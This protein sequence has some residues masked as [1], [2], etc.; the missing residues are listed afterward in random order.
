MPYRSLPYHEYFINT[1]EDFN[2]TG[3]L[4]YRVDYSACGY[5]SGW[6]SNLFGISHEVNYE[7]H[8]DGEREAI[9][10]NFQRTVGFS[11][12]FANIFEFAAKYY[13]AIDFEG[14][15]LQLRVH[16]GWANMYRAIKHEIRNGWKELHEL[17][18]E[19]E[20]EVVGWSLGSGIASLCA[21][22]LN[23]NFGL[24]PILYTFGSVR[25]FKG[26]R[27][28]GKRLR[29]Y[30]DGVCTRAYN[31]ADVNDLITYMPPF[32]G[33]MMIDRV[34]LGTDKRRTLPRLLH[35]ML[36]HTHYDRPELYL[37]MKK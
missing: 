2:H 27:R 35:P 21:Q 31:F 18:P 11:D 30:L 17:H 5:K 1:S 6:L 4:T 7:M 9:Q 19:A 12:W 13:D 20:T 37:T 16:H 10:I 28:D 34:D 15:K 22:D 3:K 8:Y 26:T 33:F 25:P 24:R 36:Y 14:D 23:F 32:R 29:K